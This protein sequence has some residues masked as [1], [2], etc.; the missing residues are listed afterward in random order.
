MAMSND[1]IQEVLDKPAVCCCRT[2]AG[3]EITASNLE[4]PAIFPDL[5]DSGL[6]TLP[7]N[8]LKVR[9]VLGAK[10]LKTV[11]SL[12]PLT[13]DILEGIIEDETNDECSCTAGIDEN[14][15]AVLKIDKKVG[16]VLG[17][18]DFESPENFSKLVD[19]LIVDLT[20]VVKIKDALGKKIVMNVPALTGLSKVHFGEKEES[21]ITMTKNTTS[22]SF[23]GGVLKIRIGEGKDINIELPLISGIGS[24][25]TEEICTKENAPAV[26]AKK[27]IIEEAT[28]AVQEPK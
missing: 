23:N 4:D 26:Q 14:E 17:V 7:P 10:L 13:A 18:E 2:E 11:D 15:P 28:T 20:N 3:T 12:T 27:V 25:P 22:M 9:N 1:H 19:S 6:I 21:E 5:E 24:Y 16:D 8:C